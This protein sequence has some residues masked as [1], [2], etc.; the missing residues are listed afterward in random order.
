MSLFHKCDICTKS[1]EARMGFKGKVV[2][3]DGKQIGIEDACCQE[4]E[5]VSEEAKK[6]ALEKRRKKDD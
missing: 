2:L 1:Q 4:C 3:D 5:E 6:E